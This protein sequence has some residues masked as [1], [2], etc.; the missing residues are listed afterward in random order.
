M[1]RPTLI[2]EFV[3]LIIEAGM[4]SSL[5]NAE[6]EA[7]NTYENAIR[8]MVAWQVEKKKRDNFFD[9]IKRMGVS[10]D[11]L[12]AK[13]LKLDE[14]DKYAYDPKILQTAEASLR[15][16]LS[17][18]RARLAMFDPDAVEQE[19]PR[20]TKSTAKGGVDVKMPERGK[21]VYIGVD[22]LDPITFYSWDDKRWA[23]AISNVPLG[24]GR[25]EGSHPGEERLATILGGQVQGDNVSFDI[26]TKNGWRWEVKGLRKPS[27]LIRPRA[28]GMRVFASA[29]KELV[30]LCEEIQ[31]FIEEVKSV[32]VNVVLTT[33]QQRRLYSIIERFV[34]DELED[35]ERG[36]ISYERFTLLRRALKA[37]S[38]LRK[39]WS[40]EV[41][42]KG[43]ETLRIVGKDVKISRQKYIDIARNIHKSYPKQDILSLIDFRERL[44]QLLSSTAFDDPDSWLD[45]WDESIDVDRIFIDVAGVFVVTPEGF[46]KVPK[47]FFKKVFKLSSVSMGVPKYSV[48]L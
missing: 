33:P 14:P 26:V 5:A 16:A 27:D 47:K 45:K 20:L 43:D 11:T 28:Q 7:R 42:K 31:S 22:E 21:K 30:G 3:R 23:K 38:K 4:G 39:S 13:K 2:E 25:E 36:E 6:K 12:K 19:I 34:E 24:F 17:K 32:G 18:A 44:L 48:D 41:G 15:G 35:F 40:E 10:A 37:T 29:S 8:S 9:A 46:Y 1:K